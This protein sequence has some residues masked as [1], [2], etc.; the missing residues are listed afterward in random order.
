MVEARN[1]REE[2][3]MKRLRE[4]VTELGVRPALEMVQGIVESVTNF[5]GGGVQ[6]DDVTLVVV[7]RT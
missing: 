4:A 7:K 6:K 5:T 2:Y 1:G 3:G